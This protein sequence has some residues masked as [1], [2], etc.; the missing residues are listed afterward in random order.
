MTKTRFLVISI[1]AAMLLL[2]AP[3]TP[4]TADDA[5]PAAE[6]VAIH[7][8]AWLRSQAD[9][10]GRFSMMIG[11]KKLPNPG[12]TAIALAPI[13]TALPHDKRPSDPLR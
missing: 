13:V 4:A 11:G 2:V 1:C 10:E 7:G 12:Y 8:V 5:G 6:N 9:A 3:L